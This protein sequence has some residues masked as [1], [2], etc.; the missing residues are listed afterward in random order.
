MKEREIKFR[1]WHDV[2]KKFYYLNLNFL[3]TGELITLAGTNI[4][5]QQYTGL[6]DSKDVEI[7]ESDILLIHDKDFICP[8]DDFKC[9]V[10]WNEQGLSFTPSC[11]VTP[12]I[13]SCEV[14]GNIFEDSELLK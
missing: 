1:A 2:E 4:G 9:V 6:K 3:L 5:F 7:Y 14:I 10:E 11:L 12:E 13:Y 8:E